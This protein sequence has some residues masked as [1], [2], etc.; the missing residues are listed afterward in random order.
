M[1]KKALILA[2]LFLASCT[3]TRSP[4]DDPKQLWCDTHTPRR[5]A[6]ETTPRW[7]LDEIN[8]TNRKGAEWCGW[9]P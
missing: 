9:K 6:T 2:A 7:E 4:I 8:A 1:G 3:T 5:D